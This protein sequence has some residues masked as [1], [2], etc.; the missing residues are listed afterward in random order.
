MEWA[1]SAAVRNK[2]RGVEKF[3]VAPAILYIFPLGNSTCAINE[4]LVKGPKSLNVRNEISP[5]GK[6]ILS[7]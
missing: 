3:I 4:P 2:K 7:R 6:E 5:E 1:L